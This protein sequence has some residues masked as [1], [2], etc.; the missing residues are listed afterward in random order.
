MSLSLHDRRTLAQIEQYFMADDPDLALLLTTFGQD[1]PR[2]RRSLRL[3]R[4]RAGTVLAYAT[5]A[6]SAVLLVAACLAQSVALLWAA[7]AVAVA[8]TV[9]RLMARLHAAVERRRQLHDRV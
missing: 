7:G 2:G 8:S 1:G 4:G 3:P 9:P 6:V 5:V